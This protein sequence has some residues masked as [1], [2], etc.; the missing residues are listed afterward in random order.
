MMAVMAAMLLNYNRDTFY[1]LFY[2]IL[3]CLNNICNK[4]KSGNVQ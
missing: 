3:I 2:V 4:I 1:S